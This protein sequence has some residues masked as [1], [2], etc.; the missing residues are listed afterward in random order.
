[1]NILHSLGIRLSVGIAF[2]PSSGTTHIHYL[3]IVLIILCKIEKRQDEF[4]E[5]EAS[6][7]MGFDR[8]DPEHSNPR[9]GH[10]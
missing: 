3:T 1:M 8:S 2:Y 5:K 9:S 7:K 4:M 10:E 6:K